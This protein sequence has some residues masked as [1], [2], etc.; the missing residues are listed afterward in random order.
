MVLPKCHGS[1]S[2]VSWFIFRSVIV[3]LQECHGSS[4]GA[5]WFF[6]SAM[7]LPECHGSSSGRSSARR[8][9]CSGRPVRRP[10]P[11]MMRWNSSSRSSVWLYSKKKDKYRRKGKG[12]RCWFGDVRECRTNHLADRMIWTKIWINSVPQTAA[13]TSAFS[14]VF[15]LLLYLLVIFHSIQ[16]TQLKTRF[17]HIHC[18]FRSYSIFKIRQLIIWLK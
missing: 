5:P 4:W 16:K 12:R 14:S 18:T 8:T 17:L 11:W 6:S 2:G 3:H 15:I 7:V 13:T 9:W 10:R 1:S